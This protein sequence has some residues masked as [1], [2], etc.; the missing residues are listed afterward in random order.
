MKLVIVSLAA[1]LLLLNCKKSKLTPAADVTTAVTKQPATVTTHNGEIFNLLYDEHGQLL[2]HTTG[3]AV[4]YYKPGSDHFLTELLKENNEKIIYKHAQRD[5]QNRIIK[6]EKFKQ[7]IFESRTEFTYNNSGYLSNRKVSVE[8]LIQEYIYI[9][10]AGNLVKIEE[11]LNAALT[12]TILV[13]YYD[14]RPNTV[15][16]D[17]FD[18]KQIGFVTDAQFGNQ[19]KNLVKS[20]KAI[21]ADG[22]TGFSFQYFYRADANGYVK[23]MEI[24]AN[25]ETLK[26]YNFIFQ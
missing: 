17:L 19:S 8:G 7:D 10:D 15:G 24:E 14:H 4:H 16:I 11:Y 23:S 9:Y 13:E 5:A 3:T 26:K 25:N 18:F 2:V 20:L 1:A 12:S 21:S 22:Q 6:L